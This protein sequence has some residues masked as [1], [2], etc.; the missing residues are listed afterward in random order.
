MARAVKCQ[1]HGALPCGH[2]RVPDEHDFVTSRNGA[3]TSRSVE[4]EMVLGW[5][6]LASRSTSS[7]PDTDINRQLRTYELEGFDM[8]RVQSSPIITASAGRARRRRSS[9]PAAGCTSSR[10]SR[11][12]RSSHSSTRRRT[13]SASRGSRCSTLS[14]RRAV[15][16]RMS[17]I[18]ILSCLCIILFTPAEP[19]PNRQD[20]ALPA[21]P[22]MRRVM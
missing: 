11:C 1:G 13:A 21:T 10:R 9:T 6:H 22:S 19:N 12:A 3:W 5:G 14:S 4:G 7:Q 17:W 2:L 20:G 16:S 8:R 18:N 15:G